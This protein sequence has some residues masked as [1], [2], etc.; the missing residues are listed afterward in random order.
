MFT[1]VTGD[2][3]KGQN[4]SNTIR[5]KLLFLL[6]RKI[7]FQKINNFVSV[8]VSVHFDIFWAE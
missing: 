3:G 7:T 8:I 6:Q 4:G 2:I 5:R 1:G